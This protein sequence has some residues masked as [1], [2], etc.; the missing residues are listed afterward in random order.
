MSQQH[1]CY[2][3]DDQT[4]TPLSFVQAQSSAL[5]RFQQQ[6]QQPAAPPIICEEESAAIAAALEASERDEEERRRRKRQRDQIEE[7][8]KLAQQLQREEESQADQELARALKTSAEEAT[9][10]E[11]QALEASLSK[12]QKKQP[13]ERDAGIWDC[14]QC[15]YENP[16]YHPTCV[17]CQAKP[18]AGT[19]VFE[20]IAPTLR[21]G[22]ELELIITDGK[23]DGYTLEWMAQELT[24]LGPPSVQY[25]GYSHDT[26]DHWKIVTDSSLRGRNHHDLCLELVSPVLQGDE[27]LTQLRVLM[28]HVRQLGI[29]TNRTCGFHVHI[30]ATSTPLTSLKRISQ[31]FVALENAFDLL[32]AKNNHRRSADQNQFCRSNRIAFG[33]QSNR[34]R[35]DSIGRVNNPEELVDLLNPNEDRYRKL[36]LT[37]LINPDRPS[38]ME[39]RLHGGVEELPEAE[40]WVRLLLR[41]CDRAPLADVIP[42][43]EEATPAMELQELWKI[44]NCTG[45][46]QF[47]VLGRKLFAP[48]LKNTWRCSQCRKPFETSRAL[49]QHVEATGHR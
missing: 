43:S 6:Q 26:T 24:K 32:V 20:T 36:N 31:W 47:Y 48:S 33:K 27:G 49:S 42:L 40:A 9:A 28:E 15:T 19:L 11:Q 39:F 10:R 37:N 4:E 25:H 45:L 44:V 8:E 7:Q 41:F 21:F 17:L 13:K 38:T 3:N 34:Q 23:R 16:P 5:A 14:T 29:A 30:D 46:E 35:W 2:N 18:P 22:L 12:V 1:N